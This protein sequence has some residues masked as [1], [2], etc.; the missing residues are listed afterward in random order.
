MRAERIITL[1]VAICAVGAI[2][3]IGLRFVRDIMQTNT[4]SNTQSLQKAYA[5][6]I[7]SQGNVNNLTADAVK[8]ISGNQLEC[9]IINLQRAVT[10]DPNYRDAWVF[11]G[12]AQIKN[13]DP[14]NAIKSLSSA[15]KIDPID[16]DTYKYL[17][18]A[19]TDS[20]DT[21]SAKT[22]QEIYD[23]LSQKK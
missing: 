14:Q 1:I 10:I 22:A 20:G 19:Y 11:L 13:N 2:L 15:Q 16:P 3:Y 21:V 12:Y 18:I 8:L 6:E 23:L 5:E 17:A 7:S 9:G 4:S